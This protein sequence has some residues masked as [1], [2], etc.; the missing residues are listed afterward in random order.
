[1]VA[2]A[3][4]S[5]LWGVRPD[6]SWSHFCYLFPSMSMGFFQAMGGL[7]FFLMAK[8]REHDDAP[9]DFKEFQILRHPYVLMHFTEQLRSNPNSIYYKIYIYIYI[10]H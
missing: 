10:L 1:M 6:L 4:N 5:H 7:A 8:F 2:D 3:E 9:W